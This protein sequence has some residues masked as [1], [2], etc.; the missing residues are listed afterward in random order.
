MFYCVLETS[1]AD[2]KG[3]SDL[4]R[5]P[6]L[7]I[8]SG[9][10]LPPEKGFWL[11]EAVKMKIGDSVEFDN[12]KDAESLRQAIRYTK[13]SHGGRPALRYMGKIGGEHKWRVWRTDVVAKRSQ[14]NTSSTPS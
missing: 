2:T 11:Q 10:P 9:V 4:G 7:K 3:R 12:A 13:A 5:H 6:E 8:E 1:G 14:S